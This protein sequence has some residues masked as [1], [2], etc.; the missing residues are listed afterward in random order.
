MGFCIDLF[1]VADSQLI[2]WSCTEESGG[3]RDFLCPSEAVYNGAQA[4]AEKPCSVFSLI[5]AR[6]LDFSY[7]YAF[8][9][10]FLQQLL[11]VFFFL[12]PFFKERIHVFFLRAVL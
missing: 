1:P 6:I 11:I 7:F 5:F 10:E 8:C 12:F 3:R 9:G 4:S 2:K